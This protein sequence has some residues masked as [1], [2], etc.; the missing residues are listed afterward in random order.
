MI[1][2]GGGQTAHSMKGSILMKRSIYTVKSYDGKIKK[3]YR[4]YKSAYNFCNKLIAIDTD[5]GIYH[6]GDCIIGC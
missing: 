4:N 2:E 1:A 6:N 3:E 5:C